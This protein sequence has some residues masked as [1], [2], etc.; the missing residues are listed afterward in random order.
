MRL[1][2]EQLALQSC[3]SY[4]RKMELIGSQYVEQ[5]N[6]GYYVAGVRISLDSIVYAYKR[7]ETPQQI[8]EDFP[9]LDK[10]SRVYG[11]IAF[12]LDNQEMVEEYLTEQQRLF[13]EAANRPENRA[14][15]AT[16][17]DRARA[18][19]HQSEFLDKLDAWPD[20][21]NKAA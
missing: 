19:G 15:W 20:E 17:R 6:G 13:D 9:L 21:S 7:G 18:R 3:F 16:I 11:A 5:R 12:Y 10:L 14:L 1:C 2:G 8:L 4:N